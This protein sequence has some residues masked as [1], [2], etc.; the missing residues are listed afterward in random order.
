MPKLLARFHPRQ[1][2]VRFLRLHLSSPQLP[3]V[4][5]QYITVYGMLER[6]QPDERDLHQP[7]LCCFLHLRLSLGNL[8][9]PSVLLPRN[10]RHLRQLQ[11]RVQ[12]LL[13][14]GVHILRPGVFLQRG[15]LP[16]LSQQLPPLLI[17]SSVQSLRLL[18]L[19]Q[20][21]SVRPG[22]YLQRNCLVLAHSAGLSV[23]SR[24]SKMH[25]HLVG[26]SRV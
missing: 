7:E 18:L 5:D 21:R 3:P 2:Q 22:Q 11:R 14:A 16:G 23:P 4:R 17:G 26:H 24:L 19:L 10:R 1:R 8:H 12:N 9:L 6:L 15:E 13:S 25:L 20:G